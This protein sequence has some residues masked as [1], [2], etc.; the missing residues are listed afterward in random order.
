MIWIGQFEYGIG[1]QVLTFLF[2][3]V[4]C[5]ALLSYLINRA[6]GAPLKRVSDDGNVVALFDMKRIGLRFTTGFFE[7]FT[8]GNNHN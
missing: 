3:F 2:V 5:I 8:R 4:F 1:I 6:V 7:G